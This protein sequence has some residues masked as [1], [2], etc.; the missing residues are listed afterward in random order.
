MILVHGFPD[1][2]R[3]WDAVAGMLVD[4]GYRTLAPY[5]RGFGAT[6]FLDEATP[7]SGQFTA[8]GQDIIEFAENLGLGQFTLIGHD[9]GARAAY[10]AAALHPERVSR[11]VALAVGYGTSSPDQRLSLEQ[12]RRY[13]YQW[14][15]NLEQGRTELEVNR[16]AF[17]RRLW[18][19][20]APG[21]S[22]DDETFEA[23]APSF[24]NPGFVEV[25]IHSYRY[26]WGEARGDP[27]YDRLEAYLS[28]P[29]PI[30]VPTTV[31][32][33]ADDGATLPETSA[34]KEHLFT[35]AYERRVLPGVG[36]FIQRESPRMV[37][38][39]LL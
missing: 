38:Q 9:W 29:P 4:A 30:V 20:W 31:L 17:C 22:L 23:T 14:Y 34:D 26:R 32:M 28:D 3:T 11:L 24:D 36:H 5:V 37:R 2:I 39:A 10:I 21:W 12:I 13:W 25:A 18:E 8:L 15:F 33:G 19:I 35:N 6:R 27:A 7:R 1:D 16:R